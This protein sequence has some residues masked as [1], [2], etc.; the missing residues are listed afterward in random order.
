[1]LRIDYP[2]IGAATVLHALAVVC[3]SVGVFCSGRVLL[4]VLMRRPPIYSIRPYMSADVS[5]RGVLLDAL[6]RRPPVKRETC[7]KAS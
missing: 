5:I 3:L 7:L 2:T 1:V 6:M 4:D